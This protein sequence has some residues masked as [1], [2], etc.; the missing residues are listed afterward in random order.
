M[1]FFVSNKQS[2]AIARQFPI[3]FLLSCLF[4]ICMI[5]LQ[6]NQ[7]NCIVLIFIVCYMLI[8]FDLIYL[9][10][11]TCIVLLLLY[12]LLD[13]NLILILIHGKDF[14]RNQMYFGPR[15]SVHRCA[16]V[17]SLALFLSRSSLPGLGNS[18]N[19]IWFRQSY[20]FQIS[21]VM[22]PNQ[23]LTPPAIILGNLW[24]AVYTL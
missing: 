14:F 8:W 21:N 5:V 17:C 4:R 2:N 12:Y 22:I 13:A 6:L 20:Y 11:V 15:A 24:T 23:Q 16:A 9:N 1:Q 19:K 3:T 7:V 10:Q 18:N